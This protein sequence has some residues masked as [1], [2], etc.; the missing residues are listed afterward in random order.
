MQNVEEQHTSN[1]QQ[2]NRQH[3]KTI[4]SRI[5]VLPEKYSSAHTSQSDYN[6]SSINQDP[7]II[8]TTSFNLP[9]YFRYSNSVKSDIKTFNDLQPRFMTDS[10]D[11]DE[12]SVS[13]VNKCIFA[14]NDK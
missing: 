12:E 6:F 9:N 11:S 4:K 13:E 2:D 8:V 14:N 7:C 3:Q 1:N 5:P 10:S